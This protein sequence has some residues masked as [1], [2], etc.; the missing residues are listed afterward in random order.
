MLYLVAT[1]IGNLQDVTLRAIETLK[2]CD[3]I[4]CEDTR[5]SQTFLQ[6]Y[7]IKARLVSYHKFNE[8]SKCDSIIADIKAGKNIAI[9]S[10]A[11]MPGISDPGAV[12][13]RRLIAEGLP[14][15]VV[16][17]ACALVDSFVLSGFEA[18]F[19]FVGFL[20][21]K[22]KDRKDLLGKLKVSSFPSI[23]YVSPHSIN[24]F[25]DDVYEAFGGRKVCVTRE[26]TKKFEEVTFTT[27]QARYTGT[28]KGEFVII[29]GGEEEKTQVSQDD[30]IM[31]ELKYLLDAGVTSKDACKKVADKLGLK[32][33]YVYDLIIRNK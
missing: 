15:T 5:T 29:V 17:G 14:Y 22:G 21:E 31:S 8:S 12:I 20:P 3:Y 16:P 9:I 4:A 33:N 27:L 23:F 24:Q 13:V 18:P 32:K 2:M 26:L 28:V 25:F 30:E 19:T 1:P 6:H 11:G 10:D 7:D